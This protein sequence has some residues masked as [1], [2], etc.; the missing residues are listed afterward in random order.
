M[1]PMS[2]SERTRA[3][4]CLALL[5]ALLAAGCQPP[6]TDGGSTAAP[7]LDELRGATY[8]GLDLDEPAVTLTNGRWQG[9]PFVED[10]STRPSVSLLDDFRLAGDLDGD[11]AEEAVTLLAEN[12]GGSGEYL[13]LALMDRAAGAVRN[14]ATAQIGDRVEV[15]DARIEGGR[16]ILDVVQPGPEDAACCPGALVERS[17]TR[18]DDRLEEQPAV[19]SGRLTL[20]TIGGVEWVLRAWDVGRPSPDSIEVTLVFSE[21]RFSGS[22]GCNRYFAPVTEGDMPG[23]VK[24]GPVAATR[25]AC[26]APMMR[27]EDRFVAQLEDVRKFGFLAGRLM[28]SYE[29]GGGWRAM[30]LERRPA[31]APPS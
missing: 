9:R 6:A 12:S 26:P 18:T 19:E 21:G 8:S 10:G 14:V 28:L 15:R 29:S 31:E 30:L 13:Y 17:W 23:D 24:V 20:E 3:R 7:T 22:G 1:N 5:I 4:A 27:V 11:G 16:I 2:G 25:M